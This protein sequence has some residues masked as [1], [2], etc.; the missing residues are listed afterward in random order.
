MAYLLFY[1]IFKKSLGQ[2]VCQKS[3]I[4]KHKIF[5]EWY[6]F[7]LVLVEW[8]ENIMLAVMLT[9]RSLLKAMVLFNI[10]FVPLNQTYSATGRIK[11]IPFLFWWHATDHILFFWRKYLTYSLQDQR[12]AIEITLKNLIWRNALV[13]FGYLITQLPLL[14]IDWVTGYPIKV[15]CFAKFRWIKFFLNFNRTSLSDRIHDAFKPE[16]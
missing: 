4:S 5:L 9:Q 14:S 2:E 16:K 12:C 7:R 3:N 1:N 11:Y 6:F 10:I 15:V 13:L 8:N